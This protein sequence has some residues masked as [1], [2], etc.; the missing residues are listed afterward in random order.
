[1]KKTILFILVFQIGAI[2][3]L[4]AQIDPHFSQ[5]YA[6]PLWL[7]PALT[8]AFD[9]TTRFTA[10]FKDQWTGI[11]NGYQ[12]GAVSA[13]FKVTEKLSLGLNLINQVAGSANFDYLAAYGT[14]GYAI[15]LSSDGTKKLHFGLQAGLIDRSF[16]PYM[17]QFDNQYNPLIGYD[18]NISSGVNFLTTDAIIFDSGAGIYYDDA[19]PDNAV[20]LF[21]GA[22]IYHIN[23]AP[24]PFAAPGTKTV[25]PVR[26]NVH[27]GVKITASDILD[28]TPNII[29]IRQQQ[30]QIRA[31]DIYAELKSTDGNSLIMGAMY[32]L[33]DAVVAE[34]GYRIKSTV[35]GISYDINTSPLNN[36]TNGHGGLELS[37]NYIFGSPSANPSN[38]SPGF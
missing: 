9:G 32:R 29:Y 4:K 2:S 16:N 37:L 31:I 15:A 7:N 36:A 18:P 5:I 28:I 14:F 21:G 17:L 34:F 1:M 22:S 20:K 12:T 11:S 35:I 27:G 10:N 30:N 38:S 33:D 13:D 19:N 8:G 3:C 23:G 6:Y 26:F 25:L 24:D